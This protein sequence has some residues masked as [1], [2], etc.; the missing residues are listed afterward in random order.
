MLRQVGIIHSGCLQ[1]TRKVAAAR[2]P[3]DDRFVFAATLALYV[4]SSRDFR[5]LS[6]ISAPIKRTV[7]AVA[8]SPHT[9]PLVVM[10]MAEQA[11]TAEQRTNSTLFMV[12]NLDTEQPV[13]QIE[14]PVRDPVASLFWHA[15]QANTVIVSLG[16]VVGAWALKTNKWTV[17]KDYK[18]TVLAVSQSAVKPELLAVATLDCQVHFYDLGTSSAPHKPLKFEHADHAT[19]VK[20]DALSCNYLLVCTHMG[21]MRLVDVGSGAQ[22]AGFG[23]QPSGVHCVEFVPGAP[24]SFVRV[25][26][27]SGAVQLY[28]VSQNQPMKVFKP[29]LAMTHSMMLLPGTNRLL[30]S[31][32]DGGVLVYDMDQSHVCWRTDGGH[33]ETIFDCKFSPQDPNL[34]A[35]CSFD[36][37]VRIYDLRTLQC[38]KIISGKGALYCLSWSLDGRFIA[39]GDFVG[40]VHVC[41]VERGTIVRS[42]KFHTRPVLRVAFSPH[43]PKILASCSLDKGGIVVWTVDGPSTRLIEQPTPCS[44]I[45]WSPLRPNTLAATAD[46]GAVNVYDS[47]SG[48]R[49]ASLR[50]HTARSFAVEWSPLVPDLLAS[51]SNDKTVR[52]WDAAR[53]VCLKV[54][55]GHTD[56]SR[57]VLWH[58][59]LPWLLF[60]GSWD[61]TIRA[62]D[63]RDGQCVGAAMQHGADVYGLA[64][65]PGRPFVMVSASRDSTLQVW[66]LSAGAASGALTRALI[67]PMAALRADAPPGAV[68]ATT[69]GAW[70]D[71]VCGAGGAM[72]R[73]GL[74]GG[75]ADGME[76]LTA[77]GIPGCHALCGK[78]SAALADA[79]A[80]QAARTPGASA[81]AS[82]A[83]VVD[84]FLPPIGLPALWQLVAAL[85]RAAGLSHL[86]G[87]QQ[88]TPAKDTAGTASSGAMVGS[89][90]G[91]TCSHWRAA[92]SEMESSASVVELQ[93]SAKGRGSGA[94]GGARGQEEALLRRAASMHL[95]AGCPERCCEVLVQLGDWTQALALAPLAGLEYWRKL[96]A[97]RAQKL[98]DGGAPLS[99]LTPAFIAAGRHD[100]LSAML[101]AGHQF[102]AAF[103]LAAVQACGHL[104]ASFLSPNAPM[105]ERDAG[106][107][108]SGGSST[109][110]EQL[111]S[112]PSNMPSVRRRTNVTSRDTSFS[113]APAASSSAA[114]TGADAASATAVSTDASP[115][116]PLHAS[117]SPPTSLPPHLMGH[118]P[119]PA[120]AVFAEPVVFSTSPVGVP[121][122]PLAAAP[123]PLLGHLESDSAVSS[124]RYAP[125][126]PPDEGPF[127]AAAAA[128]AAMGVA[129]PTLGHAYADDGGE[130]SSRPGSGQNDPVQVQPAAPSSKPQDR[131]LERG[132]SVKVGEVRRIVPAHP[133]RAPPPRSLEHSTEDMPQ[134]HSDASPQFEQRPGALEGLPPRRSARTSR[135]GGGAGSSERDGGY[136]DRDGGF[137]HR[138]GGYSDE[139]PAQQAL[140][141]VPSGLRST[142]SF[143]RGALFKGDDVF[144]SGDAPPHQQQRQQQ[145]MQPDRPDKWS[146]GGDGQLFA[147]DGEPVAPRPPGS[148]RST[149]GPDSVARASTKGDVARASNDGG[150]RL[151]FN[152]VGT[153]HSSY[154]ASGQG[155]L[156]SEPPGG[157]SLRPQRSLPAGALPPPPL[158]LGAQPIPAMVLGMGSG[159]GALSRDNS[160]MGMGSHYV[161]TGSA[162]GMGTANVRLLPVSRTPSMNGRPPASANSPPVGA[163]SGGGGALSL[164]PLEPVRSARWSADGH[165]PNIGMGQASGGGSVGGAGGGM[166]ARPASRGSGNGSLRTSLSG[167]QLPSLLT[168]RPLGEGCEGLGGVD[169]VDSV[170]GVDVHTSEG[171]LEEMLLRM[172]MRP[173]GVG[174]PIAEGDE[175]FEVPDGQYMRSS[176]LVRALLPARAGG[177]TSPHLSEGGDGAPPRGLSLNGA[178]H[179]AEGTARTPADTQRAALA[180]ASTE[181]ALGAAISSR[182]RQA[183]ALT[184]AGEWEGLPSSEVNA[185]QN[186]YQQQRAGSVEGPVGAGALHT[187]RQL[188]GPSSTDGGAAFSRAAGVRHKQATVLLE[189]GHPLRAACC[190]ASVDD[191]VGALN[192]LFRA[193]LPEL[194][195]AVA[196]LLESPLTKTPPMADQLG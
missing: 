21:E 101:Q 162:G 180:A 64:I 137:A 175:G 40:G 85:R 27:K 194:A 77:S 169:G 30:L 109:G 110:A 52:V 66:S 188:P 41:D 54:L 23:K 53:G 49:L 4:Y 106:G 183:G 192:F 86:D 76:L 100:D 160:G 138:D 72:A 186:H 17:L 159:G 20:W 96:A 122:K 91:A 57:P 144:S 48:T 147:H 124:P 152:G 22:V 184:E 145:F 196:M 131:Q 5:L 89:A 59:E 105:E 50:G 157:R 31:A 191:I 92:K 149:G 195:L 111:P 87:L 79:Q 142:P 134:L 36:K 10:A 65:H 67:A 132:M 125:A 113:G 98:A 11:L 19:D 141:R 2:P 47:V 88:A 32:E 189:Q 97:R 185:H 151:S 33:T 8:A 45:S 69:V 173:A 115:S 62:W 39:M 174:A 6:I 135:S 73:G 117:P 82:A 103:S 167:N 127:S 15:T 93:A 18:S 90:G 35:T 165:P 155:V 34:L 61:S 121:T 116:L 133:P 126:H 178:G 139:A 154:V 107:G 56:L 13:V 95:Q 25:S 16:S 146:S 28:N 104:P 43:N 1:W 176:Q 129:V 75:G 187:P 166:T 193:D 58:S 14:L 37:T 179:T 9:E 60:S 148:R 120:P 161:S 74:S 68:A 42:T 150:D 63:V 94:I 164:N 119:P 140:A 118:T 136:G 83:A 108:G 71:S 78:G 80:T 24:G 3:G 38:V 51:S 172:L 102:D 153:R 181:A 55:T 182:G 7:N 114:A 163:L 190:L 46:D 84:F 177:F 99:D 81:S 70:S 26:N 29:G 143:D 168:A 123:L 171:A 112:R 44:G 158:H 130:G 128:A 170:G 156:S 12:L